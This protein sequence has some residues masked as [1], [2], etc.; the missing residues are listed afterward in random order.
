MFCIDFR[1]ALWYNGNMKLKA[2][3]KLNLSLNVVGTEG[4]F[5]AL[6]SVVTSVDV[7]DT[8]RVVVRADKT[9]TVSGVRGVSAEQNTAY[10]L[11][12]QFVQTFST[13]GV[14]VYIDKAIPFCAG[15]GGSSADAAAVAYALAK[16]NNVSLDD[17]RLW[18][19]CNQ[20]GSDV[21]FMLGGGFAR[22]TGKGQ[23]VS[24]FCVTQPL[25]FVVTTF[26][27]QCS[28]KDVFAAFDR[29]GEVAQTDNDQLVQCLQNGDVA[30]AMQC[31]YNA[32][33]AAVETMSN[34]ADDYLNF[35]QQLGKKTVMTGSGSAYFV[36][37][38]TL[39]EAQILCDKLWQNG[40][41]SRVCVP[42]PCGVQLID[43]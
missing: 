18:Q 13:N 26:Q 1:L 37:C 5:H 16:I 6:D 10:R 40:F 17:K 32:L 19:I 41:D 15:M 27:Q 24:T 7:F 22:M 14:D 4:N 23:H 30:K 34:Y 39:Q 31:T 28:T 3:A 2:Y 29:L 20:V 9:V 43:D 36:C 11:A 12:T 35:V 25:Y 21:W 42:T 38:D 8:V 33:Q